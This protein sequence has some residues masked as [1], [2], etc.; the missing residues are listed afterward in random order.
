MTSWRTLIRRFAVLGL[1]GFGGPPAHLAS[2]RKTWIDSG[3]IASSEFED[4][5]AS[6][7]LLPGPTS[8]QMAMWV[9]WR[10][11][12]T[13]GASVAAL[14][15]ITPA[16]LLVTALAIGLYANKEWGH[17]IM[18]CATGATWMMPAIVLT[19]TWSLIPPAMK[20]QLRITRTSVESRWFF[21]WFLVAAVAEQFRSVN[22]LLVIVFAGAVMMFRGRSQ[23]L[24]ARP[25]LLWSAWSVTPS[26]AGLALKIGL[27]SVGGGLVIVPI[28]RAD[29]V[30][31]HH[32]MSQQ[33][34]IVAVA[35]GQLTPGPVFSTIAAIGYFAAGLPGAAIGAL[36]AFLPSYL[37]VVTLAPQ[38][39]RLRANPGVRRFFAGALPASTGLILGTLPLF[40]VSIHQWVGGAIALVA[41]VDLAT[42]RV[43]VALV[44]LGG[45][46]A[47]LLLAHP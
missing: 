29:A 16:V 35:L 25:A 8:T 21:A 28:M 5:L 34:F 14:L 46:V 11:R 15:F 36:L 27:L 43:P 47:G 42:K 19:T 32:W 18:K 33:D 38:L 44:L 37:A 22:P 31:A 12:G 3:E 40:A 30:V 7:S 26:V 13:A 41:L 45:V 9:G 2:L 39:D 10:Q 23:D 6:A 4:A 20:S 17:W 1:T 24:D